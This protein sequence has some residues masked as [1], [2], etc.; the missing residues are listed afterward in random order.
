[1]PTPPKG[2]SDAEKLKEDERIL[3]DPDELLKRANRL[4]QLSDQGKLN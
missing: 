4:K 1:V 3:S 2:P